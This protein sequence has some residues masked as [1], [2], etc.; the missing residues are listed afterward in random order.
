MSCRTL[1][2]TCCRKRERQ[3]SGGW[4]Q[5]GAVRGSVLHGFGGTPPW[6]LGTG[7][8]YLRAVPWRNALLLRILRRRRFHQG[9]HQ[10]LI[11]RNPVTDDLPLCPVPLLEL[12]PSAP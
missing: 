11:R 2:L 5:S 10:G 1:A 4:R 7:A 9:P 6:L 8:T 12:H 3:H